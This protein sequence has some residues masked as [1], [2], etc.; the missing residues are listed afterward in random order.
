MAANFLTFRMHFLNE[1]IQILIKIS[2]KFV[3]EVL[4]STIPALVCL[5]NALALARRQTLMWTNDG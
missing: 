2:R 4:I 3:R 1:N 5:D